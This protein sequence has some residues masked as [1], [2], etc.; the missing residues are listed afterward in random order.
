[1][2]N[3]AKPQHP[4]RTTVPSPR[5]LAVLALAGSYLGSPTPA[6][7]MTCAEEFTSTETR[8]FS[9]NCSATL[10][11]TDVVRRPLVFAGD[12]ADN[13][14]LDCGGATIDGTAKY[15]IEIRS[16]VSHYTSST[17]EKLYYD[18]KNRVTTSD[19]DH[20]I[21]AKRADGYYDRQR[22]E[23]IIIKNCKVKGTVRIWGL[24]TNG[25]DG[26]MW[27]SSHDPT[28]PDHTARA[29]DAAPTNITFDNVQFMA[30]PSSGNMF[31]VAPGGTGV[32]VKN[33]KFMRDPADSSGT[34][35]AANIYLDAESAY[36]VIRNNDFQTGTDGRELISIDG[37]SS[38]SI[39]DNYFSG[40]N[41]GG[42]YLYRNCGEGAVTRIAT[43]S[44]NT[45]VNNVFYYKNYTGSDPAIWLG[46]RSTTRYTSHC[47][48]DDGIPWGSGNDNWDH[49]TYNIVAQ[50]QI[51]VRSTSDMIRTGL[52]GDVLGSAAQLLQKSLTTNSPNYIM[53]NTTTRGAVS[54]KAGC[55]LG[56]DFYQDLLI[57]DGDT[58]AVMFAGPVNAP[59]CVFARCNDGDLTFMES[60]SPIAMD[61]ECHASANDGGCSGEVTCPI[62][63]FGPVPLPTFPIALTGT[64]NLETSSISDADMAGSQINSLRVQRPS[65][66]VSDGVCKVGSTQLSSGMTLMKDTW[67]LGATYSC[68]EHDSN[69]GDCQVRGTLYCL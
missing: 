42:I 13:V 59:E 55:Y 21:P 34:P 67:T 46:S 18:D 41:N 60:C 39:I 64:C 14:T 50:N 3:S 48:E 57:Q 7:A 22:P 62:Q 61:Y 54:R 63:W 12:A 44:Y 65:D 24:G 26:F 66:V 36:N 53:E 69:G 32:I 16:D 10:K 15:A 8:A 2:P 27:V 43:P 28:L 40:L 6:L 68:R 58:A 25:Q 33:S 19:Q 23:N 56:R 20:P 9:V 5:L 45:I 31:Y 38:N 1:M 35:P 11:P 17:G 29:R 51:Y 47:S 52:T 30:R 4:A 49:A 37:S